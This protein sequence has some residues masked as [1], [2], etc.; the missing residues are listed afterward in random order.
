MYHV[1]Q[2]PYVGQKASVDCSSN[3]ENCIADMHLQ[4]MHLCEKH[5]SAIFSEC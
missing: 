4:E 3:I 5:C 2:V 1:C